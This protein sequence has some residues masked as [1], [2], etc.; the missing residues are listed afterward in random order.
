MRR[1][2][3]G[4]TR[5]ASRRNKPPP[6]DGG[7]DKW[8]PGLMA[9]SMGACG[10]VAGRSAEA[11]SDMPNG[12]ACRRAQAL[13]HDGKDSLTPASGRPPSSAPESEPLPFLYPQR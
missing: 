3:N 10:G 9:G 7:D 8:E 13:L 6:L 4:F 5:A 1:I 2:R 12:K 11:R